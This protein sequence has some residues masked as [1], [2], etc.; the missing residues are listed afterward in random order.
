MISFAK[1]LPAHQVMQQWVNFLACM[2]MS[3]A[4]GV[5]QLKSL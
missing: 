4:L 1:L 2:A 3:M 5:Q